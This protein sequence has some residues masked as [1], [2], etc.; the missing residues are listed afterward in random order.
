M[1][2]GTS[3]AFGLNL[4]RSYN[5]A[6]CSLAAKQDRLVTHYEAY[7]SDPRGELRRVLDFCEYS[8]SGQRNRP[9]LPD[10]DFRFKTSQDSPGTPGRAGIATNHRNS[11]RNYA[12][13]R[14][15]CFR[16]LS[17]NQNHMATVSVIIPTHAR[18]DLLP[19]AVDSARQAGADVEIIV[20]DDASTGRHGLRSVRTSPTSSTFESKEIRAW[21][22][23]ATSAF[24]SAAQNTSRFLTTMT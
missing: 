10:C 11:I 18:P 7:F 6:V 24:S 1:R 21:P 3:L 16:L 13:R 2:N 15:P 12:P 17:G 22:A 23:P 20:V 19:R 4:W 14:V 5:L 8:A 9:G